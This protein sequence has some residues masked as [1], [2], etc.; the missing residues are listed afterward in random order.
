VTTREEM[1][2]RIL[3]AMLGSPNVLHVKGKPAG[4][5]AEYAAMAVAITNDLRAA[6]A[7]PE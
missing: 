6:L 5:F 1:A 4:S 3:C 2:L 7:E